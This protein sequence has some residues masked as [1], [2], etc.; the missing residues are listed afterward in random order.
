ME[1]V[2]LRGF[3][4]STVVDARSPD[5]PFQDVPSV[6]FMAADL[7]APFLGNFL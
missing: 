1:I 7:V 6:S 5:E 2:D 4:E 3:L